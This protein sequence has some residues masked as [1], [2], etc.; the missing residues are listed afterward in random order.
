MQG[1]AKLSSAEL[2][3]RTAEVATLQS[4]VCRLQQHL[5]QVM[6]QAAE[7]E[8]TEIATRLLEKMRMDETQQPDIPE[9]LT[10]QHALMTGVD[11]GRQTLDS[12]A[13]TCILWPW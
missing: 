3:G 11:E 5:A 1:Q 10:A 7:G 6:R 12:N 8:A 13:M 4:T 2:D 9:A